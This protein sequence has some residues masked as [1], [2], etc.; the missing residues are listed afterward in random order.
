MKESDVRTTTVIDHIFKIFVNFALFY[1]I[2]VSFL[3]Y[4]SLVACAGKY[5]SPFRFF[6]VY[7]LHDA[8]LSFIVQCC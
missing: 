6:H 7:F 3:V 5:F 2:N 4:T 8:F 1:K